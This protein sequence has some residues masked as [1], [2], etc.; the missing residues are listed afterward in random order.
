MAL[1]LDSAIYCGSSYRHC[2]RACLLGYIRVDYWTW[3]R[4]TF[5]EAIFK[6]G[7]ISEREIIGTH[8]VK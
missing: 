5:I 8:A 1:I 7:G 3:N 2:L 6:G 4:I